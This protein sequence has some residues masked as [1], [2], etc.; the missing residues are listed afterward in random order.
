MKIDVKR[1]LIYALVAV[2][3]V[4][5]L[6][7]YPLFKFASVEFI[8]SFIVGSLISVINSIIG[9]FILKQGMAKS[10]KE[11]LK[12]TIGSMG[13]RLF[14]IAGVIFLLLKVLNFEIYGL[15]ISLLLFYF[16]FLGVEVL[17]LG[18]LTTKREF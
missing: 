6:I 5:L 3:V 18:K 2:V 1:F 9:I 8:K 11:F 10:N 14:V 16:V 4:W 7:S 17:F 13:I 15:I 12:L